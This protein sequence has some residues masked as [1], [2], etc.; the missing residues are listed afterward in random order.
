MRSDSQLAFQGHEGVYALPERRTAVV[1]RSHFGVDQTAAGV[2]LQRAGF[3]L[4]SR[5]HSRLIHT[6]KLDCE[7]K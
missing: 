3:P 5:R 2:P 6:V 1:Q 7:S 4:L